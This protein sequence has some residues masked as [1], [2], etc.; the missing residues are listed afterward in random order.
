[1]TENLHEQCAYLMDAWDTLL[2]C[3]QEHA[4]DVNKDE[5]FIDMKSAMEHTTRVVDMAIQMSDR[6]QLTNTEDNTDDVVLTAE[7]KA[8]NDNEAQKE[9]TAGVIEAANAN[10]HYVANVVVN[11]EDDTSYAILIAE[12][13]ATNNNDGERTN[14]AARVTET[15]RE[16]AH[17]T[18]SM[19]N[20]MGKEIVQE[21]GEKRQNLIFDLLQ[22]K[23]SVIATIE[24]VIAK[25]DDMSPIQ[26]RIEELKRMNA[27]LLDRWN[28]TTIAGVEP[29][30]SGEDPDILI[31]LDDLLTALGVAVDNTLEKTVQF[32]EERLIR[33]ACRIVASPGKG[34]EIHPTNLLPPRGDSGSGTVSGTFC[35]FWGDRRITLDKLRKMRGYL[36]RPAAVNENGGAIDTWYPLNHTTIFTRKRNEVLSNH[37]MLR[38]WKK[39]TRT[40]QIIP[41]TGAEPFDFAVVVESGNTLSL[42]ASNMVC[43]LDKSCIFTCPR[44]NVVMGQRLDCLDSSGLISF[45]LIIEGRSTKV[46]AWVT[47]TT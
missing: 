4:I 25:R 13:G 23:R 24:A 7:E 34:L 17:M 45:G 14:E 33:R 9:E 35:P 44:P 3:V 18:K 46:S 30:I 15:R 12:E 16:N 42:V 31:I 39:M 37:T 47:P 27:T 21:D 32:T 6:F 11:T 8:T 28:C 43:K 5:A 38:C 20:D 36:S 26:T 41:Y 10:E 1:M 29:T 40:V 19:D 22:C 2:R